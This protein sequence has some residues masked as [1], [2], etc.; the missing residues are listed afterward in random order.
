MHSLNDS[1]VN[2]LLQIH[3]RKADRGTD[4]QIVVPRK[5]AMLRLQVRP[6]ARPKG[7]ATNS[8]GRLP[9]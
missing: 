3:V 1:T 9:C 6:S 7:T 5:L 8:E 2:D 4:I